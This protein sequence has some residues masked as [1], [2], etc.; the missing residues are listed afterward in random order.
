MTSLYIHIPFCKRKCNYCDFVSYSNKESLMD[1][2]VEALLEELTAYSLQPTTVFFGGGTPTLLNPQHFERILSRL[3]L[4]ASCELT[5]EANPGTVNKTYLK[6]LKQL[7]INRISLGAQ[8]FNDRH[9]KTLGRIHDSKQIYQAVE[10]ARS[11][12]FDNLN[13]D[14]I[15]SLPGQTLGELKEDIEQAVA[16]KPEHLST[17][18][19]QLEEGTPLYETI[20]NLKRQ[21]SKQSSNPNLQMPNEDEEAE[22]YEFIIETLTKA[23]HKHYEISN[24]AKPGKEC[25]HNVNYW[26]NGNYIGI[27]AGAHSHIEGQRFANT[28]SVEEYIGCGCAARNGYRRT[29]DDSSRVTDRR[30]MIFMGLRLLEG[31]PTDSF[32]GFEADVADLKAQGLLDEQKGQVKLTKKGLLLANLVFERFV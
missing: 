27:G 21:T 14:L 23:G 30:E 31:L 1:D 17:Y 13:L 24:F 7:G 20:S 11:A 19:L 9:L 15:F 22:M 5:I 10:D 4:A 28:D 32:A 26:K 29:S 25:R 8:T 2:Y 6:E 12:G 16:L 3:P 18:N